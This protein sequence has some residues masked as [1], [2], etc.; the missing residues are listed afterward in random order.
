MY[1]WYN[2]CVIVPLPANHSVVVLVKTLELWYI[3]SI[4]SFVMYWAT[5]WQ[6][7]ITATRLFS[8]LARSISNKFGLLT[9]A[10]GVSCIHCRIFWQT[11][12]RLD[13]NDQRD[14]PLTADFLCMEFRKGQEGICGSPCEVSWP[15]AKMLGVHPCRGG[16]R[17]GFLVAKPLPLS[18]G[19]CRL[20]HIRRDSLIPNYGIFYENWITDI[21]M[22]T[23]ELVIKQR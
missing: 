18:T 5:L 13:A 3:S 16:L 21:S 23:E 14:Q 22:A 10:R 1:F 17:P 20:D 9:F 6:K 8:Y 2:I 12:R 15:R 4:V 7:L 11:R 19:W